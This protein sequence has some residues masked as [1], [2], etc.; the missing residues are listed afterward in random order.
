MHQRVAL[1]RYAVTADQRIGGE[2]ALVRLCIFERD[3]ATL[4]C[5]SNPRTSIQEKLE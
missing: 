3:V 5:T 2:L 1:D 4:P